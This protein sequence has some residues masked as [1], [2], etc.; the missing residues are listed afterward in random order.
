[1]RLFIGID[2]DPRVKPAIATAADALRLRVEQQ[3]ASL[4]AR[5]VPVENLHITLWFIGHVAEARATA[6]LAAVDAPFTTRVFRL[7][8]GGAG[9]FPPSGAPRVFWIGVRRGGD[10]LAALYAELTRRFEPLGLE[11]ERRAYSAHLTIARIKYVRPGGYGA[12][13]AVV[14]E[15]PFAPVHCDV[16]AVTVFE[17]RVSAK[18]ATYTPMLRVPLS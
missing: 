1:V 12:M 2:I 8:L 7:E 15:T 6:V 17:S 11:P 13:R 18:G 9:V 14:Q 5:W 10:G 4:A 16:G 3:D